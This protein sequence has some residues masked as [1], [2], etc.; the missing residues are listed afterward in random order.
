MWQA[1]HHV[2]MLPESCY[3]N[4]HNI[5]TQTIRR[6]RRVSISLGNTFPQH[7]TPLELAALFFVA[8]VALCWYM[9]VYNFT[10]TSQVNKCRDAKSRITADM[11]S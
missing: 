6:G 10:R 2:I 4:D 9:Y 1:V 8:V 3:D 11:M 5:L 7:L